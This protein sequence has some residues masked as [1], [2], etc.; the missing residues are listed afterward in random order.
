M[1]KQY[2]IPAQ[3]MGED[4]NL[5]DSITTNTLYK[6]PEMEC[7]VEIFRMFKKFKKKMEF[8]DN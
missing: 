3:L 6:H 5:A 4:C 7:R 2:K 1:V 8:T